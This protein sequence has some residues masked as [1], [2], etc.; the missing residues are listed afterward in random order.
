MTKGR[1]KIVLGK[2]TA[3]ATE[4]HDRRVA[5]ALD[6]ARPAWAQSKSLRSNFPTL[7]GF[8]K[9]VLLVAKGRANPPGRQ[10]GQPFPDPVSLTFWARV[11][12]QGKGERARPPEP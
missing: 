7:K 9:H 10:P 5:T 1:A 6:L 3:E 2:S 12:S 8:R 4:R 11:V